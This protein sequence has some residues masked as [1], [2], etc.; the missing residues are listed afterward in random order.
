MTSLF[1][2]GK[3]EREKMGFQDASMNRSNVKGSLEPI[4]K[5]ES[6]KSIDGTYLDKNIEMN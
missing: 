3:T 1:N 6:D 2:R 5:I 4:A